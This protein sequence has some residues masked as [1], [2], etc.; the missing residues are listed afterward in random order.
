MKPNAKRRVL[1]AVGT[2]V[3]VVSANLAAAT[4]EA[5]T[6]RSMAVRYTD[7]DPTR[8]EDARRLYSRIK[9]AARAVCDND[10]SSE[11][12]RLR[13]YDKCVAQ[14][15]TEAVD[16]LQSERVSAILRAHDQGPPRR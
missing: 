12:K 1:I 7:L 3:A 8:P 11:L 9:R 6:R 5:N 15:L 16:K 14:A 4:P 13:E 10:P 2:L